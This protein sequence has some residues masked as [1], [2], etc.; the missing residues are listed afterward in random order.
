MNFDAA[1]NAS[2]RIRAIKGTLS[3]LYKCGQC[4]GSGYI[5]Q[6]SHISGGSC[7]AC[8]GSGRTQP[9][10]KGDRA[11]FRSL[12]TELFDLETALAAYNATASLEPLPDLDS[13][14]FAALLA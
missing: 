3:R 9:R 7:F 12:E 14:D 10:S 6:F 5:A 2:D 8:S 13:I 4:D 1:V 11:T